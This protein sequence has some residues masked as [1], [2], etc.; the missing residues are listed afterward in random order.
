MRM[1]LSY[2]RFSMPLLTQFT[3]SFG[4]VTHRSGYIL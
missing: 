4:T 3:T 2:Y 1:L